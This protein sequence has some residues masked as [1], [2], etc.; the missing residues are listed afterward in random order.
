MNGNRLVGVVGIKNQTDEVPLPGQV[1]E[2]G[3]VVRV[4]YVTRAA[5][6][7][8]VLYAAMSP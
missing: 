1:Y 7:A 8:T 3:T 2:T 5:Y 4:F 6:T